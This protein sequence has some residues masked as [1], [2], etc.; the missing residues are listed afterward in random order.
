[1]DVD[2]SLPQVLKINGNDAQLPVPSQAELLLVER[3]Q[4][5]VLTMNQAIESIQPT[6]CGLRKRHISHEQIHSLMSRVQ[7]IRE[8][9]KQLINRE[10]NKVLLLVQ[11]LRQCA[12]ELNKIACAKA[13]ETLSIRLQNEINKTTNPWLFELIEQSTEE[14]VGALYANSIRLK[15]AL[16]DWMDNYQACMSDL[17]ISEFPEKVFKLVVMLKKLSDYS[18]CTQSSVN[19]LAETLSSSIDALIKKVYH[20]YEETSQILL[21]IQD[22]CIEQNLNVGEI[23]AYVMFAKNMTLTDFKA[24]GISDTLLEQISPYV[25]SFN[26]TA[27]ETEGSFEQKTL[28]SRA[29]NEGASWFF[30][31][32]IRTRSRGLVIDL[33]QIKSMSSITLLNI[34]NGFEHDSSILSFY[35]E[36]PSLMPSGSESPKELMAIQLYLTQNGRI[37]FKDRKNCLQRFAKEFIPRLFRQGPKSAA[38]FESTDK[39]LLFPTLIQKDLLEAMNFGKT[40]TYLKNLGRCL[41]FCHNEGISLAEMFH[42]QFL[43][44]LHNKNVARFQNFF[45]FNNPKQDLELENSMI[46]AWMIL[47]GNEQYADI[48]SKSYWTEDEL[49]FIASSC[50]FPQDDERIS[51]SAFHDNPMTLETLLTDISEVHQ[52]NSRKAS[53]LKQNALREKIKTCRNSAFSQATSDYRLLAASIVAKGMQVDSPAILARSPILTI[54]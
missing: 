44:L 20:S 1:M 54:L 50:A 31:D 12:I 16:K 2:I 9:S 42:P 23:L 10:P 48:F 41:A 45:L 32:H 26:L 19:N 3:I 40:I 38:P 35:P 43:D 37:I 15:T 13:D 28:L 22:Y 47:N 34:L 51:E 25:I 5:E 11:S 39:K 36:D 14:L 18:S 7:S 24:Q 17:K 8:I 27:C 4:H 49:T 21:D 29:S 52:K 33:A 53:F 46:S 30:I 6:C